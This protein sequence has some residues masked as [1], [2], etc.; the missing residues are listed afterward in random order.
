ML[1]A[2]VRTG[3]D[4]FR[5]LRPLL[6]ASSKTPETAFTYCP[7]TYGNPGD[8]WKRV[9]HPALAFVLGYRF[10]VGHSMLE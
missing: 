6:R 7:R 8:A 9:L 10:N 1:L 3:V 5:A 2:K 4:M